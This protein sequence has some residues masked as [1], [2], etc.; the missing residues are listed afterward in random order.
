MRKSKAHF[1]CIIICLSSLKIVVLVSRVL[2]CSSFSFCSSL[3]SSIL[4]EVRQVALLLR[5]DLYDAFD[6]IFVVDRRPVSS[7]R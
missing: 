3:T 5:L 1:M 7:Q 2:L 6:E 4:C